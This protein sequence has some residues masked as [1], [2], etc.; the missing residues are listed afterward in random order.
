M[1]APGARYP[2]ATADSGTLERRSF[3]QRLL[4]LGL[5]APTASMVLVDSALAQPAAKFSYKGSRRGGGGALKMLLW[6]GPTLLNPHLA[7]GA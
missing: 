5:G 2:W 7:N 3:M 1:K 6:Q 4:G